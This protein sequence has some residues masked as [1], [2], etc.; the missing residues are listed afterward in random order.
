LLFWASLIGMA[1]IYVGVHYPTD[2][3]A[4]AFLGMVIALVLIFIFKRLKFDLFYI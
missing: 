1:Q 3:I 2:I 4:G